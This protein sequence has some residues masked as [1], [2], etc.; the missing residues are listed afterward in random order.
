TRSLLRLAKV[1]DA[2]STGRLLRAI[3]FPCRRHPTKSDD[4]SPSDRGVYRE[5]RINQPP[6]GKQYVWERT[7][8]RDVPRRDERHGEHTAAP[9]PPQPD[10]HRSVTK[11]LPAAIRFANSTPNAAPQQTDCDA[12]R[13]NEV[14]Q[15]EQ[16]AAMH[17]R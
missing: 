3:R 2:R 7:R 13:N 15:D 10:C 9:Q 4:E 12:G 6:L 14:E 1:R 8:V 17:R 5:P 16:S 11:N